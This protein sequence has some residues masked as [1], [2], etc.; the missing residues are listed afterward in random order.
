MLSKSNDAGVP[1][2]DNQAYGCPPLIVDDNTK[3]TDAE[4]SMQDN[5]IDEYVHMH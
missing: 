5:L 4:T 3:S 2:G 1:L